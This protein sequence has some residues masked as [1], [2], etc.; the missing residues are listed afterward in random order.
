MR[1]CLIAIALG[2]VL[3]GGWVALLKRWWQSV[4]PAGITLP[5]VLAKHPQP[6]ERRVFAVEGRE[7]LA[8]FGPVRAFPRFPSGPP[9]Y[10]FDRSGTL[11]DWTPDEGDDE[12]FKSR[13]PG[14]YGGRLVT[15][16]EVENWMPAVP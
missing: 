9:V 2:L 15:G 7:Y 1:N 6:E 10:V 14:F 12:K 3:A 4:Q 5:A 13:W 8:L 16:D 11:V